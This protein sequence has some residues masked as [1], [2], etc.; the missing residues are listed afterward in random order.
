MKAPNHQ[1]NSQPLRFKP[2]YRSTLVSSFIALALSGTGCSSSPN[3]DSFPANKDTASTTQAES[4]QTPSAASS[5][6]STETSSSQ[7]SQAPQCKD[8]ELRDCSELP[9][10]TKL[11]FPSQVAQ[12]N[13]KKGHQRCK[14]GQ[15]GACQDAVGPEAEDRCDLAGDDANCNSIPNEGCDCT[16]DQKPRSCG[17]SD[18]GA[19]KLGLQACENGAWQS[20]VGE[21]K[22]QPEVCDNKG[23]DEDCDGTVDLQDDDCECVNDDEKFCSL[24]GKGDCGLGKKVCR[25]GKWSACEPRFAQA[26][27]ETCGAPQKDKLGEAVGDEDCDG[28]ID[29]HPGN[30]PAPIN[31]E[32]YMIDEDGDGFGALGSNYSENQVDF[33]Y[34]CFCKGKLPKIK[35]KTFVLSPNET[36]NQDCGD[37]KVEGDLVHPAVT[38]YAVKPSSCLR[39][40]GWK[41]GAYDYNCS[42]QEEKEFDTVA[43]CEETKDATCETKS[44]HWSWEVPECGKEAR[45]GSFCINDTPPCELLAPLEVGEQRCR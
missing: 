14:G 4:G 25:S 37:C 26:P 21:I 24:P 1:I 3:A 16:A 29:N 9:D 32:H 34:G 28:E 20:C 11:E 19:C 41:W 17:V 31:C 12:G 42:K 36:F 27:R 6:T 40:V 18:V 45:L 39:A 5:T 8:G 2:G 13:C 30:G 43:S 23:I 44:G 35:D 22:A 38:D 7:S 33:T 10:G 15:W